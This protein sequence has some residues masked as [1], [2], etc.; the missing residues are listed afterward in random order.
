MYKQEF[1]G[2]FKSLWTQTAAQQWHA[3][4][5]A[6]HVESCTRVVH[7][8]VHVATILLCLMLYLVLFSKQNAT[9]F[10]WFQTTRYYKIAKMYYVMC[11]SI[12]ANVKK[13]S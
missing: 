3:T 8:D 11:P 10:K 2:L 7:W 13:I 6:T 4:F 9:V 12:D 5:F 1:Q